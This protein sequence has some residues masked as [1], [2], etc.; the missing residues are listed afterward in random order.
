METDSRQATTLK[1]KKDAHNKEARL[2]ESASSGEEARRGG[3]ATQG[4]EARRGD[5]P[6]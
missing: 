1:V 2:G 6:R 5:E 3:G 4:E